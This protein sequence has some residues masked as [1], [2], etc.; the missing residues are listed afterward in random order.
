[1]NGAGL[2]HPQSVRDDNQQRLQRLSD[3]IL[4]HASGIVADMDAFEDSSRPARINTA[5]LGY[6]L[7]GVARVVVDS[8]GG[9]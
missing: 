1:M 5:A 3:I 4:K 2:H 7:G 8:L 9:E 6:V